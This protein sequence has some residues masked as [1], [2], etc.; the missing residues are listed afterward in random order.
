RPIQ[1]EVRC[2]STTIVTCFK[3]AHPANKTSDSSH[4]TSHNIDT[5]D[6]SQTPQLPPLPTRIEKTAKKCFAL[7]FCH[8]FTCLQ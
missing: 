7:C 8:G 1:L 2:P 6:M 5:K 4:K 3:Q